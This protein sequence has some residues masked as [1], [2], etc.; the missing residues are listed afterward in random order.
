MIDLK[1]AEQLEE[2]FWR[3]SV[4]ESPE[5]DS[6]DNILNKTSEARVFLEKFRLYKSY[7]DNAHNVLELG[8]G[9]CWA[10][11]LVKRFCPNLDVTA[12]DLSEN[13]IASVGKWATI[14][15]A[16]PNRTTA[17][18][19]YSTPFA[20]N[21]FQLI[22][23]FAAAHHFRKYDRSM[24]EVR[25]L[26]VPGGSALFFYEPSCTEYI[27]KPSVYMTNKMHPTVPEDI[28]V[29]SRLKKLAKKHNL[30]ITFN[31]APTLTNRSGLGAIYYSAL[32]KVKPLTRILPCSVDILIHKSAV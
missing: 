31:L 20:D 6:I 4:H 29:R 10:S 21:S 18:R 25:R 32:N 7:F 14:Y 3:T 19:A 13:A 11:C 23:A 24:G 5:S 30:S 15:G 17:C 1:N 22:F 28:L 12:T 16:R 8:G 26:L 27:Y 2:H 9:Q